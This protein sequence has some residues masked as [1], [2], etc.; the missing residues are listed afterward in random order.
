MAVCEQMSDP[1]AS[2]GKG[3]VER[4]WCEWSP[5]V[6]WWSPP[7]WTTRPNNYLAALVV[8]GDE[9]GL[10]Y[11]DISTGEYLATQLPLAAL[12][13]E[14]DRISPAEVLV[15]ADQDQQAPPGDFA[16]TPLTEPAFSRDYA[17]QLLMDHFGVVSLEAFGCDGL[18]LAIAAAG[19]VLEYL[20]RTQRSS[21]GDLPPLSTYSLADYMALDRQTRRNLE[22][23]KGGLWDN[24]GPS[25]Y[26]TL[27]LTRTSMGGACCASGWAGPCWTWMSSPAARMGLPISTPTC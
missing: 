24:S 6:Q 27:D 1:R 2:Q 11:V 3:L 25:L 10:A 13:P 7:S 20:V 15:P 12:A 5:R 17:R 18:P 21:L 16:V 19:A 9:C 4:T 14:L 23:F 26:S 22:L 8:Q